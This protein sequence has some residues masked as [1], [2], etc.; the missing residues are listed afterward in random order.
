[1]T[2]V[3]R[4]N[5]SQSDEEIEAA[6]D[7]EGFCPMIS[8]LTFATADEF[9]IIKADRENW[10]LRGEIRDDE[11]NVWAVENAQPMKGQPRRDVMII[12]FGDFIAIDGA[13]K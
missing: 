2:Y 11:E 9:E 13:V 10:N 3:D 1:M 4:T 8:D 7:A 12:R 5:L 6:F